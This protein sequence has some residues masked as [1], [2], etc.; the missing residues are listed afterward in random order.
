VSQKW[1]AATASLKGGV[2]GISGWLEVGEAR[3]VRWVAEVCRS[4]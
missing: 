4:I 3:V 1:L 2:L